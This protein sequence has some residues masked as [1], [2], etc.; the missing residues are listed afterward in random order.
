[1]SVVLPLCSMSYA[2]IAIWA[3]VRAAN[4]VRAKLS[5]KGLELRREASVEA[6]KRSSA[7]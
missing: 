4:C 6:A 5:D 7:I 1:M 2:A 3:S